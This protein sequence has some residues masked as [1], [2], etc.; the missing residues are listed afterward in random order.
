MTF[1]NYC[2]IVFETI[3]KTIRY[4]VLV[5][6]FRKLSTTVQQSIH[7]NDNI[8]YHTLVHSLLSYGIIVWEGPTQHN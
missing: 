3:Q 4:T 2:D 5:F 7:P 6:F 8:L 1:V